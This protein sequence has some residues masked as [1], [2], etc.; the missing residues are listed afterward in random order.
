MFDSDDFEWEGEDPE[1]IFPTPE[2]IYMIEVV[3]GLPSKAKD[4]L[5]LNSADLIAW[6]ESDIEKYGLGGMD[7]EA[8]TLEDFLTRLRL[9]IAGRDE[10]NG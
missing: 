3:R 1:P 4:G 7:S 9:L 6:I 5:Y 2:S 10:I 8:G